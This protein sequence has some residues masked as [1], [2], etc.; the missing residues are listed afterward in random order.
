MVGDVHGCVVDG[1]GYMEGCGSRV[2]TEFPLTECA[3]ILFRKVVIGWYVGHKNC[4]VVKPTWCNWLSTSVFYC[5]CA[6]EVKS[7]ILDAALF[8]ILY[9]NNNSDK[10]DPSYWKIPTGLLLDSLYWTP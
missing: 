3:E 6:H 5:H 2:Q 10:L 8:Y 4:T 7:L 1:G 9:N